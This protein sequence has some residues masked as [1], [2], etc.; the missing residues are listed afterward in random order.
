[1]TLFLA[2]HETTAQTLAWTWYMLS[3]NPAA[4]ARLQEELRAVLGGKRAGR[5]GPR[6][7]CRIC[8]RW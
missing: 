2:G 5:D 4:E 8:T 1:M 3:E 6:C 7:G